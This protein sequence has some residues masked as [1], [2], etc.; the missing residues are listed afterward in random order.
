MP[1]VKEWE[2]GE[3]CKHLNIVAPSQVMEKKKKVKLVYTYKKNV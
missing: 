1:G 3:F 2:N